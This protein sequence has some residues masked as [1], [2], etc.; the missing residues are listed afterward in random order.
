MG[1]N[2]GR[3]I[4]GHNRP[5]WAQSERLGL[6]GISGP[7]PEVFIRRPLTCNQILILIIIV[8]IK[9]LLFRPTRKR[10]FLP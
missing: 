7:G 9:L 8:S 5:E 2:L 3:A 4:M 6:A 1:R 10:F